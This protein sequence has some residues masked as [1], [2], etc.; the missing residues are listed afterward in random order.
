MARIIAPKT[1]SQLPRIALTLGDPAGIGPEIT[2]AAATDPAVRARCTPVIV[3]SEEIL[4]RV[5]AALGRALPSWAEVGQGSDDTVELVE[6][7]VAGLAEVQPGQVSA[8]GGRAAEAYLRRACELC[9][10][11]LC[12]AVTTAPLHKSSL[13][14]AGIEDI[15][16]TEILARLLPA[17]E[18]PLTLFICEKLRIFFFSRH[19]SLRAAIDAI[20]GPKVE[21]FLRRVDE[22]L[23]RPG[24]ARP[25]IALAA[26]NP[27]GGDDGQFGDEEI[28]HLAPAVA[29]CRGAG[30]DVHGPIPA[31]AVFHQGLEG[32]W[33]CVVALYHDQGHIA[34]KTRDFYGTVTATLGL[35]V[36]RTSVDH[37]TAFDLAWKGRANA[38][39]MS[40]ATLAAVELLDARR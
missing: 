18:E 30:L 24:A 14:L 28:L 32:R 8:P 20:D 33:D 37:G 17:A 34:S 29:A 13:R 22:V 40:A 10:E 11:G 23:V 21:A 16:H 7:P 3:G 6:V 9:A 31:D 39:S 15:G 12:D 38:Q 2:L 35:S 19:L 26:L 5:A 4:A 25:R 36:L 1:C 27:H